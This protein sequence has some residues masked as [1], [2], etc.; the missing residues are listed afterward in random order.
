MKFIECRSWDG[1]AEYGFL[2]IE[3]IITVTRNEHYCIVYYKNNSYDNFNLWTYENFV[4]AI[5]DN[6]IGGLTWMEH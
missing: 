4:K 2:N 3:E 5:N 1:K 6:C